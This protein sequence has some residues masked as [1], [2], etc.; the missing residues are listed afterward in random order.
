M[1]E[2]NE[3]FEKPDDENVRIWRYTDLARFFLMLEKNALFFVRADKLEDRF[4]GSYSKINVE[5][6]KISD[7]PESALRQL[8]E[9]HEKFRHFTLINCWSIN[10]Y[11]S[12]ALWKAFS[13]SDEGIAIQSTFRRLATSFDGSPENVFIGKV[14]YVDYSTDWIPESNLFYPFLHK[15]KNFAHENELRA[16]IQ[17]VPTRQ[18]SNAKSLEIDIEKEICDIGIYIHVDLNIL[19]ESIFLSPKAQAHFGDAVK[20][21]LIKYGLDKKV[22]LSSLVQNP[23]Y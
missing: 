22:S 13:K 7:I 18:G 10:E 19:I 6:R 8:P 12:D 14:R 11:E 9:I 3:A 5:L 20:A 16:I 21:I 17:R 2:E 4:E 23:M 15:R 1:Y